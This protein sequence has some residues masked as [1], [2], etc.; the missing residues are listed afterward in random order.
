LTLKKIALIC[1]VIMMSVVFLQNSL[2]VADAIELDGA[3][4]FAYLDSGGNTTQV[5]VITATPEVTTVN[6]T[7]ITTTIVATTAS[8]SISTTGGTQNYYFEAVMVVVI[9]TIL[10]IVAFTRKKKLG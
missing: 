3:R 10:G 5:S 6:A 2:L 1:L 9:A 7:A 4:V 8:V